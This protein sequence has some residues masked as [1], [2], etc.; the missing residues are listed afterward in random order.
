MSERLTATPEQRQQLE[1]P[2]W[3]RLMEEALTM[4]GQLS[5]I[6]NRF[7]GYSFNNQVLLWM[8]GVTEPVNTYNRWR[9]MDRQV[10]KGSKAKAILRPIMVKSKYELDD[11]GDPK[12]Y[13]RFKM[14]RCL[15]TASETEGEPLPEYEPPE[16]SP[17]RAMAALAINEV[18]FNS[19]DGNV[20]G[21]SSGRELA[22]NPVAAYPLKTLTHELAHISLGHTTPEQLAEYQAHRGVKEAQA[23][24]TAYIVMNDIGAPETAWDR[25]GSRGYIQAY[26]RNRSLS[27]EHIRPVFKAVDAILKA[28][29]EA[30]DETTS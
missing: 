24:S 17:Q 11:A 23:E 25:A 30:T 18:T 16:W 12:T 3:T 7:Y 19:I 22:I 2:E 4:P 28:G 21:W 13:T 5:S 15:F 14:V 6:Y 1:V 20:Q 26:L 27:D 9:D 10:L 8:Q 29:R